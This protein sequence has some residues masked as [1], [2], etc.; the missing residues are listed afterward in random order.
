V[1]S[2]AGARLLTTRDSGGKRE[3]DDLPARSQINFASCTAE[4]GNAEV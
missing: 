4:Q 3:F 1:R 2:P